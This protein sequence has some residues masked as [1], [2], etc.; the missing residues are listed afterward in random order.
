[1]EQNSKQITLQSC[2]V[3]SAD[4]SKT[5]A[6]GGDK[7]I[8]FTVWESLLSPFMTASLVVSDSA[9][10]INRFPLQGGEIVKLEIKSSFSE[11]P[12]KYEFVLW[13]IANRI[14]KNKIQTYTLGLI[15]KEAIVNE[16]TRI[17]RRLENNTESIVNELLKNDLKTEKTIYSEPSRFKIKYTGNRRRPF[18]IIASIQELS[19]SEKTTYGSTDATE[20]NSA[21]QKIR[22]SAGFFFWENYRGYNFFS[23]DSLC[24]EPGGDFVSDK[25]NSQSWGPYEET[26]ANR[27]NIDQRF[28]ISQ[29]AFKS[30][31]DILTALRKGKYSSTM[32]FFNYS[33]GQY[34]EYIYN[35]RD[36]YDNMSHLGGQQNVNTIKWDNDVDLAESPT[37][38][39]SMLLDHETWYNDTGIASPEEGDGSTSPTEFADWQ[40]YYIAQGIARRELLKNQ[41]LTIVIPGNPDMCSGDKI[42]IRLQSKLQDSEKTKMP[43]D[44]ESSGVY[45][46]KDLTH[47]FN[48]LEGATGT[49]KTTLELFRD[50]YGLEGTASNHGTK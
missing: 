15:S 6:L 10:F 45:L 46:I 26:I 16:S 38:I 43:Y 7:I 29:V 5:E 39:M 22:G 41:E 23:I 44:E 8:L 12:F 11:T 37:R 3:T 47:T 33:T 19:V 25:L 35:I 20:S 21:D 14:S 31:I 24:G 49:H 36:S 40:K 28:I 34:D 27:D 13:K 42:D 1:M 9:N 4:G 32:V 50:S 18:D 30:E 17:Y 48:F 2:T